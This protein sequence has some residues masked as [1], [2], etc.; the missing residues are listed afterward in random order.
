MKKLIYRAVSMGAICLTFSQMMVAQPAVPPPPPPPKADINENGDQTEIIIRQKGDKDTKLTLEI[1]NGDY[2]I[3]GK[4]LDKFDDQNIIIEKRKLDENISGWPEIAYSQSPFRENRMNEEMLERNLENL[5]RQKSLQKSI[6]IRLNSAFLGVSS[7]KAEKG[8]ATV[9]EVTKGSPAEKAGIKKGDIITKVNEKKIESPES[10]FETVHNLKPGDKVTILLTRDGKEQSVVA[11]L[12]KSDQVPKD[13]NYNYNY[14]FKM[15][16]MPDM[17]DMQFD[18]IWGPR[19]PKLGIKAQ[20]AEDG[21]GVNVIEVEDSSAAWKAGLKKGDIIL[22]FDGSE[23]N[24]TNE[25][26]E[27]FQEARKKSTIKV[28]IQRGGNPQDIEIKIPRKL[29]TAEL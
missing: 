23:V 8:G 20:D 14:K 27:Q 9:L 22:Q 11:T 2:F 13:F 10:L 25:L 21:K 17:G 16:P 19:Q 5:E 3:N 6:Q 15:P 28:R 1:K 7:R 26:V 4:P 18:G 12:D 29:K 24:S